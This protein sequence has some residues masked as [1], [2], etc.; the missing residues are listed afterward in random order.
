M[1]Y[2]KKFATRND[3]AVTAL[4]NVVL[5]ADS[6]EVLYNVQPQGVFIQHIDGSLYVPSEWGGKGF[7]NE[8]ANGV[9]VITDKASFVIAKAEYLAAWYSTSFKSVDGITTTT[10][11]E[12]AKADF[13]GK[14]NTAEIVKIDESQG[15]YL[16]SNYIFPNGATGYMPAA[17]EMNVAYENKALI[18]SAL[19]TI[20]ATTMT[21]VEY[22][23]STQYSS[24]NAWI[25][26][27]ESGTFR[28][29]GK[30]NTLHVR[31]FTSL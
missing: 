24:G 29:L 16:C 14:A 6:G 31:P 2:L 22:W 28:G 13:S 21:Y 5:I 15:A 1:K 3:V 23:T 10:N 27:W 9:A 26:S 30:T 18:N 17:G 12:E 4:P 8:D 20:G 19:E 11:V 25:I 7:S